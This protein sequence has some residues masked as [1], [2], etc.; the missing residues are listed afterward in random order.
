MV[1]R[2]LWKVAETK[3]RMVTVSVHSGGQFAQHVHSGLKFKDR[4]LASS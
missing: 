1:I 4:N 2:P 3:A